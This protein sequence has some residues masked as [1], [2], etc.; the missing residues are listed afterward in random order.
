MSRNR[1]SSVVLPSPKA[2]RM[3]ESLLLP[4]ISLAAVELNG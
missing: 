3:E 2:L 4:K 1:Q